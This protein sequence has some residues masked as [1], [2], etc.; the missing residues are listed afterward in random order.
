MVRFNESNWGVVPNWEFTVNKTVA[1]TSAQYCVP[2][3]CC[4]LPFCRIGLPP[5][6]SFLSTGNLEVIEKCLLLSSSQSAWLIA[7]LVCPMLSI[8]SNWLTS[9]CLL[10]AVHEMQ[11]RS[12]LVFPSPD[13]NWII[14]STSPDSP[15]RSCK[16]LSKVASL[17]LFWGL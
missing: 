14:R 15:S 7:G 11:A 16:L 3:L 5:K 8:K 17:P 12:S 9:V 2:G 6:R 10:R 13:R 4:F 1:W